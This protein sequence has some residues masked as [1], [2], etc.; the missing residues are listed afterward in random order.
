MHDTVMIGRLLLAFALGGLIGLERE[1]HGRAAG[2]RTHILVTVGSCLIMLTAIHLWEDFHTVTNID[3]GRIAAQVVSGIGFLG[4]GAI[5]RFRAS[6][7]GLTTAASLWVAAGL[8]LA[9]GCGY[10]AAGIWATAIVLSTLFLLTRFERR[11]IRR[12]WYKVLRV[13]TRG[14]V[15]QL[16]EIRGI[17]DDYAGEIKDLEIR[18]GEASDRFIVDVSLK[19]PTRHEFDAILSDVG[20]VEGVLSAAWKEG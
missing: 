11:L 6:V 9:V 4:A 2:L 18:R 10:Y 8:G 13:E 16:E 5:L 7:R 3:P 17:L 15:K 19:L 12:D 1:L 14:E 20:A